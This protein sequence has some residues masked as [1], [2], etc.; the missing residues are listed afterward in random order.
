M[1]LGAD[2]LEP[3]A[4]TDA[5]AAA[6]WIPIDDLDANQIRLAFD[7]DQI[8]RDGIERARAKLEYTGYA[9]A[10]IPQPFTIGELH[11]VYEAVWGVDLDRANF[12]RKVLAMSG[13]LTEAEG[14]RA[15]TR[16]RPARQ[17]NGEPDSRL[18]PPFQPEGY[19]ARRLETARWSV[20]V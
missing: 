10:L 20:V 6:H 13:F 19:S 9:A 2:F 18:S 3:T 4:G 12:Q 8:L 1:A 17:F 14:K 7:H 15:S 11:A 16:G 5:A